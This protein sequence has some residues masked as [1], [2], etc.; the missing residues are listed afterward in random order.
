MK[1]TLLI[2]GDSFA[3]RRE[4]LPDFT[5]KSWTKLL[6]DDSEYAVVN[7]AAG[8]SSLYYAYKEF[9]QL[10]KDFDKVIL[11]ITQ[12]GRLYCPVIGETNKAH[13]N[14]FHHTGG[15]WVE[16]AKDRI[17][18]QHPHNLAAIKQLDAI[19][20]YF[21][22]VMDFTKD[23]EMNQLM[24]DDMK[25]KRPDIVMVPAFHD[26]WYKPDHP[27]SW[28]NQISDM[29]MQHYNIT[30]DDLNRKT[31]YADC[32]KCHMSERN[33]QILFEKSLKWLKGDPVEFNFSEF[34]IP[35]EPREKYFP[36]RTDWEMRFAK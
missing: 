28:L 15:F 32:R 13:L 20:D 16:Q 29:E 3:D 9:D 35:T 33:N 18:K 23:S 36:K 14:S 12:P 11:V 10:H 1:E 31:G 17:K 21:L 4:G 8:G 25:R 24:L 27:T 2:L 30:H 26:S 6:E 5:G 19:R 22:Y 34:E 7:K